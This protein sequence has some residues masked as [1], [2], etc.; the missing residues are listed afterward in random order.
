MFVN[1]LITGLVQGFLAGLVWLSC[2]I[3]L[4]YSNLQ[5]AL[6]EHEIVD[7]LQAKE[8]KKGFMIGPFMKYPFPIKCINP[9]RVVTCRSVFDTVTV[10]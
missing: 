9:I 2:V 4:L 7:S 8:I 5:S 3:Y 6:K 10:F 1:Y